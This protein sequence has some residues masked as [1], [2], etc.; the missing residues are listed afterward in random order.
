[1]MALNPGETAYMEIN[2]LDN[3]GNAD[4]I[5]LIEGNAY[6]DNF[7]QNGDGS[8]FTNLGDKINVYSMVETTPCAIV[9]RPS[10]E[11]TLITFESNSATSYSITFSYVEGENYK[12]LDQQTG[13]SVL[14]KDANS[15]TFS[16]TSNTTYQNRFKLIKS[17]FKI[18][19]T[20]DHVE[21][22]ENA[23]TDNIVITDMSGAEVVNV[24]PTGAA[25]QSIDLSGKP[26]GH[27]FLTVNGTQYEFCNKPQPKE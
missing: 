18:C 10:L 1:M 20:F 16:A 25:I 2:F 26:A 9:A 24:A 22:Y 6:T 27:Y 14:I 15:M 17:E 19:T 12:L 13:K 11:G 8:K 7:D 4:N 23:G 3:N 21:I 5:T